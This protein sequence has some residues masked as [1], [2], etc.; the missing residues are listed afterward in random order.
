M[1][2]SPSELSTSTSPDPVSITASSVRSSTLTSPEPLLMR[3]APYLPV[4]TMSAEPTFVARS[5]SSGMVTWTLRLLPPPNRPPRRGGPITTI[6]SPRC[7]TVT[8]SASRPSTW[9]SVWSVS[10]AWILTSPAPISTYSDAGPS[11]GKVLCM[12]VS[13]VWSATRAGSAGR[14][15][16][17]VRVGC[18]SDPA[19]HPAATS[20]ARASLELVEERDARKVDVDVDRAVAGRVADRVDQPGVERVAALGCHLLGLGLQ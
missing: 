4:A 11:V 15:R 2:R 12:V 14:L 1:R 18:L 3:A 20:A 9:I 6:C 17:F 7:S 16:G 5:L 10:V 19:G 13:R 8:S